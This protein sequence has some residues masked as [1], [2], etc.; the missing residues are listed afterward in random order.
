VHRVAFELR[1]SRSSE[2]RQTNSLEELSLVS[3]PAEL[4]AEIPSPCPFPWT[5]LNGSHNIRVR[6]AQADEQAPR[7]WLVRI[8]AVAFHLSLIAGSSGVGSGVTSTSAICRSTRSITRRMVSKGIPSSGSATA[9]LRQSSAQPWC[10]HLSRPVDKADLWLRRTRIRGSHDCGVR[11][12]LTAR[13]RS[14]RLRLM[15]DRFSGSNRSLLRAQVTR[16]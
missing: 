3:Q 6:H 8:K 12:S 2:R 9:R 1:D 5:C 14:P 11:Q 15:R 4:F 7:Q 10:R 16:R 13:A